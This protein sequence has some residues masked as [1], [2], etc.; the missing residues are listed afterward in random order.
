MKVLQTAEIAEKGRDG[1]PCAKAMSTDPISARS[2]R[3]RVLCG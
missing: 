2:T 1:R 3:L